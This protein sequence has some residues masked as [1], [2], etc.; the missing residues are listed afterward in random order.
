MPQQPDRTPAPPEVEI[1]ATE[2]TT[3]S[4][5]E[6][7]ALEASEPVAPGSVARDGTTL[8]IEGTGSTTAHVALGAGLWTAASHSYGNGSGQF[9]VRLVGPPA[10]ARPLCWNQGRGVALADS[11]TDSVSVYPP[12]PIVVDDTGD[13]WC[14]P[15][16][17]TLEVA[18]SGRWVVVL[19]NESPAP[20]EAG[21]EEAD[22]DAGSGGLTVG[23]IALEPPRGHARAGT[24]PTDLVFVQ[25]S[26]GDRY[27]CGV[28]DQ[29]AVECW[30]YDNTWGQASPPP[31]EFSQVA[32]GDNHTCALTVHGE[33]QCWGDGYYGQ[34]AAPAGA[35][36]Q[37]TTS[38]L[39]SCALRSDGSFTCWGGRY[40]STDSPAG[41]SVERLSEDS[42]CGLLADATL[43][44]SPWTAVDDSGSS[45]SPAGTFTHV[46]DLCGV[47][48]DGSVTCWGANPPDPSAPAGGTFTQTSDLCGI[49][50]GGEI[51]CWGTGQY[52]RANRPEQ[53]P[54]GR[55]M[56]ISAGGFHACGL[57]TD[58]AVRCWGHGYGSGPAP[59]DTAFAQVSVGATHPCGVTTEGRLECWDRR[60]W[61]PAPAVE[62]WQA[63]E[64]S[65]LP[66][67]R[68]VSVSV[69]GVRL[70]DSVA[71]ALHAD[72]TL[73]CFD[74]SGPVTAPGGSFREV[75]V[76]R[77]QICG[78]R[79]DG[80]I[81]CWGWHDDDP[82]RPAPDGDRFTAVSAA[83]GYACGVR[84][85][86]SLAC[87]GN[88]E[89]W[90]IDPPA[91]AYT[92]VSVSDGRAC[93][94][95]TDDRLVCW[96]WR[97]DVFAQWGL[98]TPADPPEGAFAAV[99]TTNSYACGLTTVGS[100]ECWG[101]GT[102]GRADPP[103]GPFTQ[104]SVGPSYACGVHHEGAVKCWG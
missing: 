56:Q 87:W 59:P 100:I 25:I 39:I 103:E 51:V 79:T 68:F 5:P 22:H 28:T 73:A 63:P 85:D 53:A 36:V 101:A 47:R 96:S 27:A 57:R 32:A 37:V 6:L 34:T 23:G 17:F 48:T 13:A 44:C 3:T 91:G 19:T 38:D 35:F 98:R 15:G 43:A 4:A 20:G 26:V 74:Y 92:Q 94:V 80:T 89:G 42:S 24:E 31:G 18:A 76:G 93:A 78:L 95:G 102:L 88:D 86:G 29:A 65:E 54:P 2:P 16:E 60:Y 46:G 77:R 58:G 45:G 69:G 64:P 49:T 75:S 61:G 7:A 12:L 11:E 62:G 41:L 90:P 1:T 30:G 8:M 70:D 71:C 33:V 83:G 67:G 10:S 55:Y 97:P 21:G 66:E 72:G 104:I 82:A 81:E 9:I 50:T 40:G 84:V 14:E 99:S 52:S